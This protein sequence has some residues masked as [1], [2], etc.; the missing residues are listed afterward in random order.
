MNTQLDQVYIIGFFTLPLESSRFFRW[1]LRHK[2]KKWKVVKI[3]LH[4]EQ[5]N[6]L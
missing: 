2:K 4:I 1:P 6:L 3:P 5:H